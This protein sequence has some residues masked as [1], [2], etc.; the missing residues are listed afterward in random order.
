MKM[1]KASFFATD[2]LIWNGRFNFHVR[3]GIKPGLR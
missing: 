1:T 2:G 3:T